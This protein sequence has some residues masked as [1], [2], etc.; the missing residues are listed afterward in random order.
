MAK[1]ANIDAEKL[2]G[3][4]FQVGEE[5]LCPGETDL[6]FAIAAAYRPDFAFLKSRDVDGLLTL[7][8]TAEC[9][10]FS[11]QYGSYEMCNA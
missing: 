11:Q 4:V 1:P 2:S 10:A 6:L 7:T 5:L 8:G 3:H 9:G